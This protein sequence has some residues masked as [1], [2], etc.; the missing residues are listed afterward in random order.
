MR[1]RTQVVSG[2]LLAVLA[3]AAWAAD[4]TGNWAGSISGPDGNT[5][6]LT[7]TFKQEGTKL[8]G[9]VTPPQGDVLPLVDGKVEGDK[10]SFA[11]NV[12]MGGNNVKFSSEGTIKGDEITLSTT[13][14]AGMDMGGSMKLKRVK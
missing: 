11:V 1:T 10:I 12:D 4:V 6:D 14:D 9:T 3:V 7:Y 5:F 8:T 13:N 2:F